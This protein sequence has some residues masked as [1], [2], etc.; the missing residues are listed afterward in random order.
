MDC[1]HIALRHLERHAGCVLT[2]EVVISGAALQSLYHCA[3]DAISTVTVGGDQL[4]NDMIANCWR[5]DRIH[6][7]RLAVHVARFHR[8]SDDEQG[9]NRSLFGYADRAADMVDNIVWHQR[10]SFDTR[11]WFVKVRYEV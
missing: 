10:C 5:S 2:K 7:D 3:D 4:K 11:T 8:C 1:H 6:E 9:V